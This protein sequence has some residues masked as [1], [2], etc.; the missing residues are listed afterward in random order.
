[1]N[2]EEIYE[3][4]ENYYYGKYNNND[5]I[6]LKFSDGTNLTA[7]WPDIN[8]LTL[9]V[10]P[11]E[12]DEPHLN[13]AIM[14]FDRIS[15]DGECNYMDFPAGISPEEKV[16]MQIKFIAESI[17]DYMQENNLTCEPG[18]DIYE[19]DEELE[20]SVDDDSVSTVNFNRL[21]EETIND[22]SNSGKP[23]EKT[24]KYYIV[25]NVKV[26][27]AQ[28]KALIV[29]GSD[30]LDACKNYSQWKKG[31]KITLGT[32]LSFFN[33][34]VNSPDSWFDPEKDYSEEL[35]TCVHCGKELAEG[36]KTTCDDCA[37]KLK[38]EYSDKH[39]G[40]HWTGD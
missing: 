9:H 34:D 13:D 26:N 33:W 20:E 22:I 17:I 19:F 25:R 28:Q 38:K 35:T 8:V 4:L 1:M 6:L 36:E 31:D 15:P 18:I 3:M 10:Y 12:I 29:F 16:N 24:Y 40:G 32:N 5:G 37:E 39:P 21:Y 30:D 7:D 2:F 23:W 14:D 11:G 27:D